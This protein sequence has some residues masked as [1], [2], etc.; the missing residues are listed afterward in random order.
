MTHS[1]VLRTYAAFCLVSALVLFAVPAHAQFRPRPLSDPATGED[2]RIEGAVGLWFPRT[3]IVVSSE[4]FGIEGTSI[5]FKTDLGLTDQKFPDFR[6]VL[7]PGRRSKFRFEFIPIRYE[8][9]ATLRR[10]VVFNGIRYRVG[11]PVNSLLEWKAYRIAYEFD[12]IANDRGYAGFVVEAKYT[13]VNI[14]L[15]SPI[16]TEFAHAQAPIPAIGGIGRVYVVPNISITGE[17]TGFKLPEELIKDTR[18]HYVDFDL[19]GTVNFTNNVGAQIGYRSLDLGYTIKTD[20]GA[21][22]LKGMYLG[23]VARY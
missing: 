4:R 16:A 12:F 1:I 21:L 9:S 11:L 3:E 6:L 2:Y 5:D 13:D 7:K 20:I 17:V 14:N 22:V 10:D 19:Y 15:A 8:Q 23:V 18:A